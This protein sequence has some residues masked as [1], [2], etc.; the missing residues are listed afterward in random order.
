MADDH[1]E[2]LRKA[3][4]RFVDLLHTKAKLL[5]D[6]T[7]APDGA[8]PQFIEIRD[9]IEA[10]DDAIEELERA[11]RTRGSWKGPELEELEE[12]PDEDS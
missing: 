10:I 1:I 5:A 9:A 8:A 6:G 2:N 7:T 12:E 4:A 3:R 11:S